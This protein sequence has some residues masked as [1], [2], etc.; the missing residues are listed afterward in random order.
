MKYY[1]D[2]IKIMCKPS[3]YPSELLHIEKEFLIYHNCL[4]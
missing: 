2:I 3:D 1:D 4:L